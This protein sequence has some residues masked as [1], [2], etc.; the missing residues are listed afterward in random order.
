MEEMREGKSASQGKM[1]SPGDM[2]CVSELRRRRRESRVSSS[3]V[4]GDETGLE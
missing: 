3:G 1:S 4:R 2:S